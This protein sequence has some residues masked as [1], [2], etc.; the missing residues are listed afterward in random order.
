MKVY[1][2]IAA[3]FLLTSCGQCQRVYT[4]WTGDL[5]YKCTK[6]GTEIVQS[7]SGIAVSLTPDG[8]PVVCTED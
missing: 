2:I 5:T 8:L 1:L 7:D 3:S 6:N 4:N